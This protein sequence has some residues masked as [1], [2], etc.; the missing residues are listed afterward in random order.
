[1]QPEKRLFESAQADW[2]SQQWEQAVAKYRQFL[3]LYPNSPLAADAH[4]QVG[5]YLSYVASPEEATAEY[6]MTIALAPGTHDAHEAKIGIAAL[7]IWQQD[8]ETAYELF[9]QV[10]VE[11]KDWS[12]IKECTFRM[13]ELGRLIQLQKLPEQRSAMVDCGPR[14]LELIFE[15]K[16]IKI[17][18][19]EMEKLIVLGQRGATMEQLKEAAQSKGLRAWGVKVNARQLRTLPSPFIVHIRP[20]HFVVVTNAGKEKI[21]FTDPHRGNTY[22]TKEKF[23]RIWQGYALVF[24]KDVPVKLRSQLLTLTEMEAIHGGHHSHGMNLGGAGGNSASK[25]LKDDTNPCGPGLP[26][27]SVNLSN[28]NFLVQDIDFSYGGRGPSVGLT[29]TYNADDPREGPFGRSW[30]FNYD[31]FLAVSPN[32]SVDVK[33]EDGKVDNFMAR[34]DGTFDPP[35]WIH[36]RLIRNSDGTYRLELKNS[37]VTEFFNAQG[38]LAQI[39]D[40]NNNSVTLQYDGSSRLVSVT[41]ATA[42]VTQFTYSAAGKISQVTDPLGRHANF[43]YD[44]NNNL[45]STVDMAG[46]VSGFTY[47]GTSYMTS[48]TTPNGTTQVQMGTTSHFTELPN[49]LKAVVDP[50]G[51]TT[52]FEIGGYIIWVFDPRGNQTFYFN[53]AFAQTTEIEDPLGNKTQASFESQAGDLTSVTDAN[54]NLTRLNRDSRGNITRLTDPLGNITLFTYDGRDNLT[55]LVDPSNKTYFFQYDARDNLTRIINPGNG[56]TTIAYD[57]FGQVSGFTDARGNTSSFSYDSSGNRITATNPGSGFVTYTHDGIGRLASFTDPKGQVF[58]YTYDGIDRLTRIT[59][60]GG[61]STNRTYGCCK[62]SSITDS[63]GTVS[64]AYDAANRLTRF[65]NERNQVIEYGYDQNRNLVRLTYPDG[66]VVRYD[67]DAANRLK[68]VTDWLNNTTGYEYDQSGNLISVVNSNGTR[69]GYQYDVANS[70]VGLVNAKSNGSVV[71][72]HRYSLNALGNRTEA[73]SMAPSSPVLSLRNIT[74]TYDSDNRVLT[75]AGATHVHDANGNLVAV[76]GPNPIAYSYDVF[77]RLIQ[78][79]SS[80][81]NAQYQYD[82]LGNRITRTANGSTTKYVQDPNGTL[83]HVLA[84]TDNAGNITSYYVYGLGLVSK[85]TPSGQSYVYH[86]DGNGNTDALTDLSGNVVNEYAYEPYGNLLDATEI[87]ANPFRYTGRFGVIDEGNG[88]LYMR[89]R[90]YASSLGRFINKDPVGLVGGLNLY[91]Y[92]GNNPANAV[93]PVGLWY[94]DINF[95]GGDG[96]G[97]TGGLQAGPAGIF[98]YWGVGYGEGGG[99]SF[100]LVPIGDPCEGTTTAATVS[101]ALPWPR[102]VGLQ[103]TESYSNGESSIDIGIGVGLG[104]GWAVTVTQTRRVWK[105]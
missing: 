81:Q 76:N 84:E 16:H 58:N 6:E 29:R 19:K 95:T 100:T 18:D 65:T 23:Q 5:Y 72:A 83:S 105:W 88:L 17:S 78:S 99:F 64:F 104:A 98:Y 50:L 52:Q 13:K 74:S 66:K 22:R 60:P 91:S 21:E 12:M 59:E 28:Y 38:K 15:K 36:D 45:I 87:T 68:K 102:G 39:T 46:N 4:F 97:G 1:M 27:W 9:R 10:I 89:A 3:Q 85:I 55:Q 47:N 69:T 62:L 96:K 7:K 2:N 53:D 48:L 79:M 63:S 41:D 14:A 67:Y 49:V 43:S 57:S 61:A 20:D 44:A 30:T 101:G 73:N 37:K 24:T 56:A 42:R 90:Y 51:N 75:A 11:T 77:N 80:G 26:R 82:G 93:D 31:V 8:Y 25:F 70:L 34:G 103:A 71:S 32:G 54:G 33:R 40:R 86:Y 35:R 94:F 92:V